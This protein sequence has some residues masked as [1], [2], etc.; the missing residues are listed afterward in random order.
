MVI[1]SE[2]KQKLAFLDLWGDILEKY[3]ISH[4]GNIALSQ[5]NRI[6]GRYRI[7]ALSRYR[8]FEHNRIIALSQ[9]RILP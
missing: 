7:I 1:L 3:R 9:Y 8:I 4:Y 5:N 6:F 2:I